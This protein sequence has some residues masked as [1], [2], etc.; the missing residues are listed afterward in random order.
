MKEKI[1]ERFVQ[2]RFPVKDGEA[3]SLSVKLNDDWWEIHVEEGVE[4]DKSFSWFLS[5]P[6][7]REEGLAETLISMVI[8]TSILESNGDQ[9]IRVGDRNI[10]YTNNGQDTRIWWD[11][12][13]EE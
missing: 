3:D 11:Y 8:L 6:R 4:L 13:R 12:E 9:P 1:R 7:S 5:R 10:V 2:E